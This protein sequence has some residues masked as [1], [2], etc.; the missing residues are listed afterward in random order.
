MAVRVNEE[1]RRSRLDG[2]WSEG[3]AT[4]AAFL[5][6]GLAEEAS[7][8]ERALACG[9]MTD[10]DQAVET[11]TRLLLRLEQLYD[12]AVAS[13]TEP[14]PA[15]GATMLLGAVH[16][17][18]LRRAGLRAA[19]DRARGRAVRLTITSSAATKRRQTSSGEAMEL[20]IPDGVVY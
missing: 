4:I 17:T 6:A 5:L 14:A 19:S 2:G 13:C 15:A 1:Q 11:G 8:A 20:D 10:V 12:A 18:R 16:A 3:Q 9:K 7:R